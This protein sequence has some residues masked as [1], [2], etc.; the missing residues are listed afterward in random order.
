MMQPSASELGE[1]EGRKSTYSV[2]KQIFCA[3]TILQINQSTTENQ[4]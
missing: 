4:P 3:L 2:E 1:L